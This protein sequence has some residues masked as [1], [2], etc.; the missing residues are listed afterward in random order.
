MCL[1]VGALTCQA[2]AVLVHQRLAQI[3]VLSSFGSRNRHEYRKLVVRK[4]GMYCFICI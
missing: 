2:T 1:R 3:R 4:I